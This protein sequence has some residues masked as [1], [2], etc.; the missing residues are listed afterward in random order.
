MHDAL[1]AHLPECRGSG[2]RDNSASN[3]TPLPVQRLGM[4]ACDITTSIAAV[5][6]SVDGATCTGMKVNA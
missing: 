6:L 2:G 3:G 4:R 5:L 1:P